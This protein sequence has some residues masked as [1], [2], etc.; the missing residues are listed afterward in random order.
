MTGPVFTAQHSLAWVFYALRDESA[1]GGIDRRLAYLPPIGETPP[2]NLDLAAT[3]VAGGVYVFLGQRPNNDRTFLAA[4]RSWQAASTAKN[5][6]LLWLE[7]P[8]AATDSWNPSIVC[9]SKLTGQGGAIAARAQIAL[10]NYVVVL[11][12]G[13][14]ISLD[15]ETSGFTLAAPETS[16]DK[17]YLAVVRGQSPRRATESRFPLAAPGA[18]LSLRGPEAGTFAFR[19]EIDAPSG[20][21]EP[22]CFEALDVACRYFYPAPGGP[23]GQFASLSYPIFDGRACG[24]SLAAVLDPAMPLGDRT[25]FSIEPSDQALATFFRTTVGGRIDLKPLANAAL[26]FELRPGSSEDRD[27]DPFYLVPAGGFEVVLPKAATGAEQ[28]MCG[29]C[30]AEYVALAA[31]GTVLT[32]VPEQAAFAPLFEPPETESSD[33]AVEAPRLDFDARTSWVSVAAP[34]PLVYY[35]QPAGAVFYGWSTAGTAPENNTLLPFFPVPAGKLPVAQ[36]D[37]AAVDNAFPL[38]PYAGIDASE[39]AIALAFETEVL[40]QERR[41]LVYELTNQSEAPEPASEPLD[42]SAGLTAVTPVGFVGRFSDNKDT[43]ESLTLARMDAQSLALQDVVDPLRAALLTNQQ[44]LVISDPRAFAAYFRDHNRIAI[45]DWVFDLDP[46]EWQRHGTI[47]LIKNCDRSVAE[48]VDDVGTWALPEE[49]NRSAS[50]T[51]QSLEQIIADAKHETA[52]TPDQDAASESSYEHFVN[53]VIDD[54]SWNGVLFLNCFVPPAELPDELHDL[55]AGLDE[56]LF[57]AHHLGINQTAVRGANLSA[58]NSSLFG[59]I[60]YSDQLRPPGSRGGSFDFQVLEIQVLFANSEIRHFSSSIAV[61]LMQ[62]F[63][64]RATAVGSDTGNALILD[65]SYQRRGDRSVY[66]YRNQDQVVFELEDRILKRV[67]LEQAEFGSVTQDAPAND[68][69]EDDTTVVAQFTFRGTLAFNELKERTGGGTFDLFSY[70]EL[71]FSKLALEIRYPRN[72][73]QATSFRLDPSDVSFGSASARPGAMASHFPVRPIA[74]IADGD[75][76]QPSDLGFMNVGVPGLEVTRLDA[77]WFGIVFDLDLGTPGALAGAVG[78]TARLAVVWS[79]STSAEPVFVGLK[80]PGSSGTANELSLMGVLKL[81]IYQLQLLRDDREFILKLT[82][83]TLKVMGKTL[84]PGATFDF[85]LFGDPAAAGGVTSLGWY[86]AY[87]RPADT[88]GD[89]DEALLRGG[90]PALV[91][92][93]PWS[94]SLLLEALRDP[95]PQQ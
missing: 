75:A 61:T 57:F 39:A 52:N 85:F 47:V 2:V 83:M 60:A 44:F 12:R 63:G 3:W 92:R 80:M 4:F 55:A 14:T 17:A 9:V 78:F 71:A 23:E 69:D 18:Q 1:G 62:M 15:E 56:Q 66:V 65:G 21:D 91:E 53:T 11:E 36:A 7:D 5:L 79:P 10:Q 31:E 19:L 27:S 94:Q 22:T 49:F 20:A 13:C 84:P 59:L 81:T 54:P 82:G 73:P 28:L 6:R 77:R 72:A 68:T 40:A 32:F 42:P 93:R 48:L 33:D 16:A 67:K 58:G 43:W 70:D 74:M 64:A 88:A 8:N 95:P 38:V 41:E 30:A 50:L 90:A 25:A 26:R 35:A 34:A 37:E 46:S 24:L 76:A 45:Q 51:Q 89:E 86:G 29:A 87:K